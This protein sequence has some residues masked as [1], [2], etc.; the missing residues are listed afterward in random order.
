VS[1]TFF[2]RLTDGIRVTVRPVYLRDQSDPAAQ[3][4][5]FAYYVRIENVGTLPAQLLSRRWLIHDEI[6][7][8]NENMEVEGPGVVGEQPVITPGQVHEYQSF[9]I[10]KS[11]EGY[12]EGTYGFLRADGV[13]FDA[14]IPR[15]T[16][17][18]TESP[19]LPPS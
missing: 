10:L 8:D 13:A 4:Y 2:Y 17:S 14:E 15:F 12:M 16:L 3:H 11:G 18:V 1:Q 7:G 19:S 9:C 6:G 5:V